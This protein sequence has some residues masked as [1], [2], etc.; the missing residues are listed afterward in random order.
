MEFITIDRQ[1]TAQLESFLQHAG[2][3]LESFRYFNTRGFEV[4]DHHL[5]TLLAITKEGEAIGYG[6]LDQEGE[7]VWLGIA[8]SEGHIGKGLGKS[9]MEALLQHGKQL[10][11]KEI[12]LS[13]DKS[14]EPAFK[15]YQRFGF[16]VKKAL[17]NLWI[18][19]LPLCK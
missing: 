2:K 7:T 12:Q 17:E 9:L 19:S 14:N 3:S 5:V 8:L 15:L 11:V 4:L 18:L 10:A 1:N 13:V 6:H 16:T